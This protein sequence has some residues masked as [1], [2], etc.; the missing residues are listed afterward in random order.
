MTEHCWPVVE[1]QPDYDDSMPNVN[2]DDTC[3]S[4]EQ[5]RDF[6]QFLRTNRHVFAN[7]PEELTRSSLPGHIIDTRDSIPVKQ[8]PHKTNPKIKGEI[9]KLVNQLRN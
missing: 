2:L 1:E 4:D 3:L 9:E 7:R 5:L 8:R 6:K